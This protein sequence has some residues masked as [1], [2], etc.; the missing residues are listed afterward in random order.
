M[1]C[2]AQ[3][4]KVWL[5]GLNMRRG[6]ATHM[7]SDEFSALWR[8]I[9]LSACLSFMLVILGGTQL[10]VFF[11]MPIAGRPGGSD[12]MTLNIV[13]SCLLVIVVAASSFVSSRFYRQ[14]VH[15]PRIWRFR[16]LAT[17]VNS[18]L[19]WWMLI[20]LPFLSANFFPQ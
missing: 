9:I 7:I 8:S 2:F 4:S 10:A 16:L 19:V 1:S 14:L 13:G 20:R 12:A 18:W 11:Y 17:V 5:D 6:S 15:Q 3:K